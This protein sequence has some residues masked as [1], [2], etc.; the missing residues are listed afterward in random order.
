MFKVLAV[1][2]SITHVLAVD[3]KG[4]QRKNNIGGIW[5]DFFQGAVVDARVFLVFHA[6]LQI[7]KCFVSLNISEALRDQ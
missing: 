2:P 4:S 1:P 7:L 6:W 3:L 5:K